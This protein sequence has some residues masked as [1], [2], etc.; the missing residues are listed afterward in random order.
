MRQKVERQAI[1]QTSRVIALNSLLNSLN[2]K[3]V[4]ERGYTLTETEDGKV[5]TSHSEF[6]KLESDT[7]FK[8]HFHD[9]NGFVKKTEP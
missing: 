8:I 7:K 3:K 9:G 6:V 5:L 1:D 4:L 2:P